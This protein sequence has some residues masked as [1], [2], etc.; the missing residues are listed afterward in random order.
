MTA[1][2][3]LPDAVALADAAARHVLEQGQAAIDARG[4]FSIALSGGSTPRELHLRVSTPPLANQIEWNRVHVFFGDERCV[5]PDDPQSNYRMAYETLL[6]RVPIPAEHIH[7][8]RGEL[9]PQ[10]AADDYE[11]QLRAFFG[12][13]PPR[14][15]MILLGMGDNGHT[16]SLFPGLTAVHEQQRWVVAEYVAEVGMWRI[17]LTPP[18]INLA[19]EVMFLVAGA[20][21]ASMLRQV[22][23]GPFAPDERPAQI[24]RPSPG[25]LLWLV[26]AA[27]AAQLS[28][29]PG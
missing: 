12:D 2:R 1:I 8:M 19:R 26:D 20:G 28:P 29:P 22:L 23:E 21:K 18:I 27:A 24:V 9:P 5:P 11:R 14:L 6:S 16:A 15:D 25:E 7:R 10:E 13:E 4:A 17:S 3:V